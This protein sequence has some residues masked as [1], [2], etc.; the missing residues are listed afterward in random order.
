MDLK[1]AIGMWSRR[2]IMEG[3]VFTLILFSYREWIES[4]EGVERGL[5]QLVL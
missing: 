5:F 3:I 2:L 1:E 4:F